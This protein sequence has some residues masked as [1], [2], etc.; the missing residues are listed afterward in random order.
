MEKKFGVH[1]NNEALEDIFDIYNYISKDS[2]YYAIK[3]KNE[4]KEK[5]INLTFMPYIGK[6]IENFVDYGIR[7]LIY[8]SYR[9]I[10]SVN[11]KTIY[12]H[13]VLHSARLLSKNLI[14]I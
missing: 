5:I 3:T 2:I 4:I 14:K 12:I 1:I 11:L 9:I 10:Y 6:K 8:K 13:R 7:E